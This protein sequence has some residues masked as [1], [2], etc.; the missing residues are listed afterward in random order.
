MYNYNDFALEVNRR[1]NN[2]IFYK[3]VIIVYLIDQDGQPPH[4]LISKIQSQPYL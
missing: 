2:Y 3:P 4:L 1:V